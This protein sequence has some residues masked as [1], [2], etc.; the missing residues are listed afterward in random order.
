MNRRQAQR[1]LAELISKCEAAHIQLPKDPL[2]ARAEAVEAII[3]SLK[4]GKANLRDAQDE[5]LQ[6]YGLEQV[7]KQHMENQEAR[8][9]RRRQALQKKSTN[10]VMDPSPATENNPLTTLQD[11]TMPG[12]KSGENQQ[13]RKSKGGV[14]IPS[15][16]PATDQSAP[17]QQ[18]VGMKVA[19]K[20]KNARGLIVPSASNATEAKQPPSGKK[21]AP[22]M[23]NILGGDGSSESPDQEIAALLEMEDL[24]EVEEASSDMSSE[25]A[26]AL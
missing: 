18:S 17:A 2:E 15:K 8:R 9:Q 20:V 10:R 5:L 22:G 1:T 26:F 11:G 25:G 13:N 19:K 21:P 7:W 3:H 12:T 14:M 6:K 24:G 4:D 16:R 23:G